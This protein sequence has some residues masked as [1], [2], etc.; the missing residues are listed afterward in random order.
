MSCPLSRW[1]AAAL[2]ACLVGCPEAKP[3]ILEP[4]PTKE[5]K[6]PADGKCGANSQSDPLV[7]EWSS[8]A[9]AKLESLARKGQIVV[10]FEGCEMRVLHHCR[11]PG[12]YVF[13]P[14]TRKHDVITITTADELY[15]N[16]PWGA[17]KLAGKLKSAGQLSVSMT[18]VGRY[19]A[20][21]AFVSASELGDHCA[22]ATHVIA[23]LTTGSFRFFAGSDGQA[24]GQL[25]V[26][27]AGAG[28]KTAGKR[29]LLNED[30][31]E[32]SCAKSTSGDKTPP[33]GCGAI[34][35]VEVVPLGEL[36]KSAPTCPAATTWDGT[37]CVATATTACPA[38]A[39]WDGTKCIA[40]TL[41]CPPGTKLVGSS[42][43]A[44]VAAG[45]CVSATWYDAGIKENAPSSVCFLTM[46]ECQ[47]VVA[48]FPGTADARCVAPPAV[49]CTKHVG[50]E[51]PQL[52]C[53]SEQDHCTMRSQKN[54]KHFA[55]KA[56]PCAEFSS[57]R[58][59]V[60]QLC[61]GAG[62]RYFLSLDQALIP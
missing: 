19:E 47:R 46:D 51:V 18:I 13:S 14:T 1:F 44:D 56:A 4:H 30:G 20:T 41:A 54:T 15:A 33:D 37:Q 61:A 52:L 16:I 53:S 39:K 29:E 40:T 43:L 32:A 35:R 38:G 17:A 24:G 6:A 9:R 7:V 31:D 49:W 2:L 60:D 57:V 8:D 27:G 25:D 59:A 45:F 50:K 11:A 28:A 34:L 48:K 5:W 10:A 12:R 62:C 22:G 58:A 23:G 21:Q 36:K 55:T 42:C 26:M 3:P